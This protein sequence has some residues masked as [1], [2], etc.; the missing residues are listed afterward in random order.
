M[1]KL[2]QWVALTVVAVLAVLAAGWFLLVSPKRGDATAL[3]AQAASQ[4]SANDV[5]RGKLATL[6]AQA[7]DEPAQEAKI[8]AVAA[9]IPTNSDLPSLIRSL[10]KTSDVTGVDVKSLSPGSPAAVAA[11]TAPATATAVRPT[12]GGALALFAR[13][14]PRKRRGRPISDCSRE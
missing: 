2:K 8:A 9:K 14:F 11:P 10:T 6:K 3:N 5:L 13:L 12:G 1:D 4:D 7:K